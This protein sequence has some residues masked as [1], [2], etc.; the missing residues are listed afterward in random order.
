MRLLV[1]VRSV[2]E[3]LAAARGGADYIDLKDP[4]GGALGG[5]PIATISAVVAALRAQGVTQP[6][7]ATIGDWPMSAR[8]DIGRCVDAVGRCGVDIVK[9]GIDG[10]DAGARALLSMLAAGAWPVAPVLI[11]DRGLDLA[12][13]AH[14]AALGF[15]A[16][17]ADTADKQSGSLIERVPH[18]QLHAFVRV[19]R[20]R[21]VTVGLAGALRAHHAQALAALAPD[22]AGFRGAVCVHGERGGALDG[23]RLRRLRAVLARAQGATVGAGP[24]NSERMRASSAQ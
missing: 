24:S 22:F 10:A 15:A 12:L 3:A 18:E 23:Q 2:D 1:S 16:V 8:A 21:G 17:M 13:A 4:D 20:D 19:V 6:V 5:L 14:A 11:A 7:S 9:V